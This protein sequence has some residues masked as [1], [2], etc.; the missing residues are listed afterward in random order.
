MDVALAQR[1]S[2]QVAQDDVPGI[3][4]YQRVPSAGACEFCQSVA[5][6]YCKSAN[7]SP[8][9]SQCSCTLSPLTSAHPSAKWLPDGTHVA[10]DFAVHEHGELG[11]V[12]TNPDDSFTT[13]AEI[14]AS[15]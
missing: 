14:G 11:A 7:A 6:S 3:Y 9:H 4:G 15:A 2:F 12:L 8:L 13:E 1:A 5:G 10:D